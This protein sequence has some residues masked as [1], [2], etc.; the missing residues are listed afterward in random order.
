MNRVISYFASHLYK[1]TSQFNFVLS[2]ANLIETLWGKTKAYYVFDW[3]SIEFPNYPKNMPQVSITETKKTHFCI[4][5]QTYTSSRIQT[6]TWMKQMLF[7]SIP[8][9]RNKK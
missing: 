9:D 2:K 4:A 7:S 5:I 3:L 8:S 6:P 1:L